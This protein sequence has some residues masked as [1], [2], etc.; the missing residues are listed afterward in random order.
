MNRKLKIYSALLAV[1]LAYFVIGKVYH[2][3]YT[4]RRTPKTSELKLIDRADEFTSEKNAYFQSDTIVDGNKTNV[5]TKRADWDFSTEVYVRPISDRQKTLL[6]TADDQTFKIEMQKVKLS[7]RDLTDGFGRGV[8]AVAG[9][10]VVL[11]ALRRGV[12]LWLF[13]LIV[14]LFIS[15]RRGEIFVSRVARYLETTG[16]LLVV[17][18]VS[19]YLIAYISAKH[20][21]HYLVLADYAVVFQNNCNNM[22]IF[23][24]LALMIVSQIILMGRELKDDQ[25]LTI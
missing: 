10:S 11:T 6:S 15:V 22:Y 8:W 13:Y 21:M 7:A 3:E 2:T 25:A 18:Y 5:T 17:L 20:L 16:W 19:Q 9:M 23:T 14:R 1:A 4:V 24:G 12:T